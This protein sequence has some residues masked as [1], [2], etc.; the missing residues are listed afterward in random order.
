M[1][2]RCVIVRDIGSRREFWCET[3]I[4]LD[5]MRSSR[6]VWVYDSRGQA[7]SVFKAAKLSK[8]GAKIVPYAEVQNGEK[9]EPCLELE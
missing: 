8:Q 6:E 5:W 4:G 3:G 7:D 2:V 1:T 9:E